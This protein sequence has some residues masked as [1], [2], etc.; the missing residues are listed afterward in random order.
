VESPLLLSNTALIENL[1]QVR[2]AGVR[3]SVDDFGSG[4]SNLRHLI[5]LP[6]DIVKFDKAFLSELTSEQSKSRT[7]LPSLLT[8][9]SKLG[10]S[11][12]CE[13]VETSEQVE[14]LSRT[15][16]NFG[17]GFLYGKALPFSDVLALSLQNPT[18][19]EIESICL[20]LLRHQE[21]S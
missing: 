12:M 16:C 14:F 9:C 7:L 3:V 21:G 1:N 11:S 5:Q 8:L 4:Y 13:G 2:A 20:M 17:Q 6:V 18:L 15:K 10:Y 19:P